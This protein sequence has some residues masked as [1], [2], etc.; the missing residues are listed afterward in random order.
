[1]CIVRAIVS[2]IEAKTVV[3]VVMQI[4]NNVNSNCF[5]KLSMPSMIIII[6]I[7]MKMKIQIGYI[8]HNSNNSNTRNNN[9]I[10]RN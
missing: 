6:V 2:N 8:S 4:I 9:F 3:L 1:M 7:M 5:D 10:A